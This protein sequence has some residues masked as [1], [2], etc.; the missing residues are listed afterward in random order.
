MS[1]E[2]VESASYSRMSELSVR[3]NVK[4]LKLATVAGQTQVQNSP[5]P[6]AAH[7][8]TIDERPGNAL[9]ISRNA[10]NICVREISALHAFECPRV[11]HICQRRVW[12]HK[13]ID[14]CYIASRR[15]HRLRLRG[16]ARPSSAF[17]FVTALA[18]HRLLTSQNPDSPS[19]Y[20]RSSRI[21]RSSLSARRQN[22]GL[23]V[24]SE[25]KFRPC[26]RCGPRQNRH[27]KEGILGPCGYYHDC[28]WHRQPR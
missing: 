14:S 5:L 10:L 28:A 24:T 21:S 25:V 1:H 20:P 7:H 6:R 11:S 8:S 15:L 12:R 4:K 19:A 16:N 23:A 13:T 17:G 27:G 26:D 2:N 22:A 3:K 18:L 9:A